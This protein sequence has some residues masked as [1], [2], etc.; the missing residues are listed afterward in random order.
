MASAKAEALREAADALYR[1]D[2]PPPMNGWGDRFRWYASP[3]PALAGERMADWLRDRADQ[4]A[5][6]DESERA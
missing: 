4:I 5:R 3:A 6:T 2:N 1:F